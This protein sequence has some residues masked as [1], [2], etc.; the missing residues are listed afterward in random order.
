MN[1]KMLPHCICA[2]IIGMGG[3]QAEPVLLDGVAAHVNE[4]VITISE[5]LMA[6]EPVR[7][8]LQARFTGPELSTHLRRAYQEALDAIIE[9]N[10]VLDSYKAGQARLPAWIVE[11]RVEE[12][13]R[14]NFDGDRDALMTALANEQLTMAEWRERLE[15]QVIVASMRSA[16]IEQQL[17]VTPDDVQAYYEAHQ[18]DYRT[19]AKLSIRMIVLLKDG[20]GATDDMRRKGASIRDRLLAGEDFAVVAREVSQGSKAAD[21]G[22]WGWIEPSLLRPEILTACAELDTFE[23]SDLIETDGEIYIVRVDGRQAASIPPLSKVESD[24]ERILRRQMAET[25]HESW[26]ARLKHDA[27]VQVFDHPIF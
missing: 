22:D 20:P 26:I 1:L 7:R 17:N 27:V 24:I 12:F 10:L 25:L 13:I 8:Q 4:H 3:A 16:A 23:I 14:D 9:R 18:D 15:E 21:G 19:S 11:N 5:V 6:I 2:L